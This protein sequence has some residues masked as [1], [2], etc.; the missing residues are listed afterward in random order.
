MATTFR[1]LDRLG[2]GG[3]RLT[4]LRRA[5]NLLSGEGLPA[6]NLGRHSPAGLAAQFQSRAALRRG[7]QVVQRD[8]SVR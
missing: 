2:E 5:R 3:E 8:A 1:R 6:P 4:Y 7:G